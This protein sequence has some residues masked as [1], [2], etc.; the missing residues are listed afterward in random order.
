MGDPCGGLV[1]SSP[2][3]PCEQQFAH[4]GDGEDEAGEQVSDLGDRER[5]QLLRPLSRWAS[6]QAASATVSGLLSFGLPAAPRTNSA[7]SR[8]RKASAAMHSVMWRC[9]PSQERASQ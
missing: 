3:G 1:P 9:H 6:L 7:R 8:A 4:G 2:E 5:W